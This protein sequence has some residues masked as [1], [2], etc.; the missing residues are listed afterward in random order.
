MARLI[1]THI[2]TLDFSSLARTDVL[3]LKT[4]EFGAASCLLDSE[5][6][7]AEDVGAFME[8]GTVHGLFEDLV[9]LLK[10]VVAQRKPLTRL[11]KVDGRG[12]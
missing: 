1:S 5:D 10:C 11:S 9:H 12:G 6:R 7:A 3:D 2:P 4:P 8:F